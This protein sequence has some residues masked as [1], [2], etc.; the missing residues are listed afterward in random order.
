M[1]TRAACRH[2]HVHATGVKC[3]LPEFPN[4]MTYDDD[5]IHVYS[6][7]LHVH[8]RYD[9]TRSDWSTFGISKGMHTCVYEQR[10]CAQQVRKVR[11]RSSVRMLLFIHSGN[12]KLLL[13]FSHYGVNLLEFPTLC[14][15]SCG[16]S[17]KIYT[18]VC[19]GSRVRVECR[20]RF[21]LPIDTFRRRTFGWEIV[22]HLNSRVN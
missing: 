11:A 12:S 22:V 16:Q 19:G 7:C 21:F 18:V 20:T 10:A 1:T 4:L 9:D 14:V 17:K 5:L 2:V 3:D 6:S 13:R 15:Y 8:E